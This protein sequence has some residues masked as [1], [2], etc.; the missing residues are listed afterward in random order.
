M[1]EYQHDE[2]VPYKSSTA[3]KKNQIEEMFDRISGRYDFLNRF[4]SARIDILWRKKALRQLL[5]LHPKEILD[6]ATGT[7]DVAILANKILQPQKITGIDISE[8]MINVGKE[9]IKKLGLDNIIRL[10]K[11]DSEAINYSDNSFDA[12]TV[13]FGVRNFENLEQGLKEIKRVLRPGGK[14]VILEFSKPLTPVI[15][16]L[17]NFYMDF[18]SPVFVKLFSKNYDAYKYLNESVKKFPEGKNFVSILD[19][20]GFNATSFKILT[21]G[22]CAIYVGEK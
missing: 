5:A 1:N 10:E 7:G 2:V 8:G 16:D 6:V 9:K 3:S 15:K 21:P 17:Y 14:V 13:A 18:I 19:K 4:L 12:V 22:I 11:G 20:T